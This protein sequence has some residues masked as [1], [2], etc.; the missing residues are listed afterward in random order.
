MAFTF[1]ERAA[2]ELRERIAVRVEERLGTDAL[3]QLG[4]LFVGTIHAYC[5]RLLQ[6]HVPRYETYDVLDENQLNA[7]VAREATPTRSEASRPEGRGRL[8]RSIETFLQGLDVVENELLDPASVP[9]ALRWGP[10]ALSRPLERYRLLSYGQ[11]IVRAVRELERPEVR[12]SVHADL[13]HLIVDEYQDVN[14]AQERLIELLTG[15]GCRALRRRGRRSGHLPVARVRCLEHR[16]RSP[17]ATRTSLPSRS[18][19]TAAAVP[20]SSP[21]RTASPRPSPTGCR[22]QMLPFRPAS[23]SGAAVAAGRSPTSR[24][25]PATSPTRSSTSTTRACLSATWPSSSDRRAAYAKLLDEFATFDIPVQPGGRT[26]LFDQPEARVLGRTLV[27]LDRTRVARWHS[28]GASTSTMTPSSPSTSSVFDLDRDRSKRGSK[29]ALHKWRVAVPRRVRKADLIRD[30]YELLDVLG[31][32]NWDL[33]DPCRPTGLARWPGSLSFWPTTSPS[34]AV[35]GPTPTNAGEQVGGQDRGIWYYKN[36]GFH[37]LNY[38]QGAYEGFDGEA[39]CGAGRGR[40]HHDPPGEGA[41]V[42][43]GL[44]PVD[45]QGPVPVQVRGQGTRLAVAPRRSSTPLATRAATQ[46][47]AASSTSP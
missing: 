11:Q 14:P 21:P 8:F 30:Y 44:R 18:R 38:A 16:R 39:D 22:R 45:D 32:R 42:A 41:G 15:S 47:N 26:G 4:G 2:A 40:P 20:R 10:R 33:D 9:G 19:R 1:T 31:V 37:V 28:D 12:A 35:P 27:W 17:P 43:G 6:A 36:L 7:F 5:F 24:A 25:R 34:G 3:D 13:R 29:N 23:A 46:R